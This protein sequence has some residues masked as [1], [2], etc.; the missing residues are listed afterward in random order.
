MVPQRE[1]LPRI[2][3]HLN[4]GRVLFFYCAPQA[5]EKI[6]AVAGESVFHASL[7]PVEHAQILAD[8]GL[9]L[10]AFVAEDPATRGHSLILAKKA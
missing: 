9:R 4:P 5:G 10:R 2:C 6:G 7:E 8:Q 3:A 1:A